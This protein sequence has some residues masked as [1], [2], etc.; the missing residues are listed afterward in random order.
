MQYFYD[1]QVRK[2]VT[3]AIRLFSNFSIRDVD[4]E[5]RR[6][7]VLYGNISKEVAS[8]LNDNSENKF[9]S[10][11]RMSVYIT[12]LEQD[13][14]RTSDYSFVSKINVTERQFDPVKNEYLATRGKN[15]HPTGGDEW[16]LFL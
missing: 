6:I 16:S 7:P 1:G 13:R 3:Q 8:I 12:A 11:P 15:Y 5:L 4:G 14:S 9:P 2:Y 10:A